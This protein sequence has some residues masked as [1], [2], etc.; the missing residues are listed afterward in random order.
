[1]LLFIN[2][3]R[4]IDLWPKTRRSGLIIKDIM[5]FLEVWCI[6]QEKKKQKKTQLKMLKWKLYRM[7]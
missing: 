2:T 1:M 6:K 4:M 7:S 5:V 3:L